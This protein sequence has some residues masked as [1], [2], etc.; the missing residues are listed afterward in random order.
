VL[1][2]ELIVPPAPSIGHQ[3]V[4]VNLSRI[5]SQ[6]TTTRDLGVI[7]VAPVDVVLSEENVLQP[8]MLYVSKER[9]QV[10]TETNLRGAPDLAIEVLSPSTAALDRGRRMDAFAAAGVLHYWLA[11]PRSK[12]LEVYE[13]RDDRYEMT[14][15][16]AEDETFEPRL[17]PGLS[18]PLASIW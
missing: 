14:V 10:I 4:I 5:L 17:F 18:V 6:H 12:T 8:D 11:N 16:V 3:R 1:W 15:R 2:G 13:L 7:L 9:S